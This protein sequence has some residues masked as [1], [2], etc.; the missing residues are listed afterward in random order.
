MK[1]AEMEIVA[2]NDVITTSLDCI[3]VDI[4]EIDP[5]DL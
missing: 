3:I 1:F 4:D 5:A 2:L